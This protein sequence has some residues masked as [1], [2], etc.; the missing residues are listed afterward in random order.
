MELPFWLAK[1]LKDKGV[2]DVLQPKCYSERVKRQLSAD[3][4]KYNLR[5]RSRHFYELGLMI[6]DL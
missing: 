4:A 5:K 6:H 1:S 3:P 2:V